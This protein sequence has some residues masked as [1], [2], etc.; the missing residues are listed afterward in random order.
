MTTVSIC[1]IPGDE[2]APC[3]FV[4]VCHEGRQRL[5]SGYERR[6]GTWI[7][8]HEPFWGSRCWRYDR[9]AVEHS[10]LL[11]QVEAAIE[12]AAIQEDR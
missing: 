2:T 4:S 11:P 1:R 9:N 6:H 12:R 5:Q 8:L 10:D 7:Q 3:P